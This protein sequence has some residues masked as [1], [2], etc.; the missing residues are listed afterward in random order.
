MNTTTLK[1]DLFDLTKTDFPHGNVTGKDV[2]RQ[3]IDLIESAPAFRMV[4]VSLANI[5]A[6]DASFPRESVIAAAKHFR[7]EKGI[8]LVGMKDRDMVDNWKYAASAKDQPLFVWH[9]SGA[10]EIIGPDITNSTAELLSYI[11]KNGQVS[12]SKV[13]LDLGLSVQNAS[14]RL[15]KLYTQGYILR[16]EVVAESGGVEYCYESIK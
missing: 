13:A 14:T 8:F 5:I 10:F 15:K 1:I 3:L 4:E 11:V 16:S 9:D 6:T 12:T 7:S 2:Y